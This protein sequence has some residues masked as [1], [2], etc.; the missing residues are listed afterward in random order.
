MPARRG[1]PYQVPVD[2]T[3]IGGAAVSVDARVGWLLLMSRLH[4]HDPGLALGESFNAALRGVGLQADR[5]AVSR[6]ESGKVT[7]RYSVLVAYEQALRLRAGQLT[8]VVNALRRAFVDEGLRAW[9]PTMDSTSEGFHD[10]LD[11][12]FDA[13]I[14]GPATGPEWTALAHHV[15]V[16]DTMY[17]HGAVWESLTGKLINQM[18]RSVGVAYLQR[19]EAVRLLLEHRVA[20]PWLL[21]ATGDF[22][23]DPSVQVINDP[24]GVL[25]IS[26]APESAEVILDKLLTT[27]SADVFGAAVSAVAIKLTDGL[28]D[29]ADIERIERRVLSRLDEPGVSVDG[30]EELLMALPAASRERLLQAARGLAGHEL[31]A[32]AAAH[33]ELFGPETTQQVSHR[34]ADEVRSGFPA[35]HL[36]DEDSLTPRLIRE[37]LF[38]V[39]SN[40]MHYASIALLGSPFRPQLAAVLAVE[41][42]QCGLEDP[43]A[44]RFA[45]LLR[46]LARPE[47][48]EALLRWLPKAPAP[49][50]RDMA[51]TLGH[52]PSDRPLEEMVPLVKGDRSLLDR[53]L[54]YGL[55]MRQATAL[56]D[57]AADETQR[58]HVRDAAVW[59]LRQGGAVRV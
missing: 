43:L 46:Y 24:M 38:A 26:D 6:W 18:A 30:Y 21:R 39:R 45:R 34:I 44:P 59:W 20:H 3:L 35:G 40:V 8:S 53:A 15:A 23:G 41:I 27:R 22:L 47:Q 54:L 31:L 11:S 56:R 19:F 32:E 7:P 49:V 10:R 42:E 55:G 16:T 14:D 13:L 36:Y 58:E 33:G 57:L 50:A 9:M 51:L 37:A 17:V 12:L 2:T 1:R 48:E 52:L 28:Y 29:E 4:H 5:S 25:E